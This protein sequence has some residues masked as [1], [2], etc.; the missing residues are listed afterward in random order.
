MD[1]L[2]LLEGFEAL[3]AE[4]AADAA[5][6][7]AAEGGGVVVGEG[8]VDP[9]GPGPE[10]PHALEH[11]LEVLRVHVR[12]EPERHGVGLLYRL[13]QAPDLDDRDDGPEGLVAHHRHG[14]RN[15]GEDGG[16]VEEAPVSE[17]FAAGD[18][19]RALLQRFPDVALDLLAVRGR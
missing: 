4:L 10:L 16:L 5:T 19:L 9:D 8:V 14:R 13:V 7:L 2:G 12:P 15:A 17:A 3:A 11:L 6:L 18:E 1:V